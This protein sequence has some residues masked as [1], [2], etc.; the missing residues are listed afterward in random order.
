MSAGS[1]IPGNQIPLT[2]ASV[3]QLMGLL[4]TGKANAMKMATIQSQMVGSPQPTSE[5]ARAIVKYAIEHHKQLIC[6]GSRGAYK[7][8]NPEEVLAYVRSLRS[9]QNSIQARIDA[10]VESVIYWRSDG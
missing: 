7:P 6:T 4:P 1:P 10:L 5:S 3:Q 8:A 9:R 2:T